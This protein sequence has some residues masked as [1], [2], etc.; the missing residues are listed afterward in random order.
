[1]T[2]FC[3]GFYWS[4]IQFWANSVQTW[5]LECYEQVECVQNGYAPF[6]VILNATSAHMWTN[7]NNGIVQNMNVTTFK[8]DL[9]KITQFYVVALVRLYQCRDHGTLN[10]RR[11]KK[12]CPCSSSN[13]RDNSILISIIYG[14]CNHMWS[15]RWFRSFTMQHARIDKEPQKNELTA[16]VKDNISYNDNAFHLQ[17]HG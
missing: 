7:D 12:D 8:N 3:I 1:M 14:F 9:L 11:K 10:K 2:S 4:C 17:K 5:T 13:Q 15:D 6:N 16:S